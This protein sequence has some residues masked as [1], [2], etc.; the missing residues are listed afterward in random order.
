MNAPLGFLPFIA[1]RCWVQ[2]KEIVALHASED[3]AL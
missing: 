3:G 2:S 1:G